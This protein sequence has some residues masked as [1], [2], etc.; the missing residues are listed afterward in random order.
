MLRNLPRVLRAV[1][2]DRPLVRPRVMQARIPRGVHGEVARVE[3]LD[4]V[5]DRGPDQGVVAAS[6]VG[7]RGRRRREC[8]RGR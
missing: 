4:Q 3:R 1:G 5:E 8:R 6:I 7:R 2:L